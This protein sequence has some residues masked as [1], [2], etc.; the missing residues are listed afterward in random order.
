MNAD[1]LSLSVARRANKESEWTYAKE[2]VQLP[3]EVLN[4][5]TR[6]VPKDLLISNLPGSSSRYTP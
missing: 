5:S 2:D 4:V 3:K 1:K 6:T